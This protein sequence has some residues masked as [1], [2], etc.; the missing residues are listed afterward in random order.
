MNRVKI[1]EI[2]PLNS[3]DV[4]GMELSGDYLKMS[5]LVVTAVHPDSIDISDNAIAF[6]YTVG[7]G[8]VTRS[9]T[10]EKN[11]GGRITAFTAPDGTRTEVTGVGR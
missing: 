10:L 7:G 11:S 4:R 6:T 5:G 8:Q 2:V 1:G 3:G 9:Y